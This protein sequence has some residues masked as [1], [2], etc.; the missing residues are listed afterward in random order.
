MIQPHD[1]SWL[2]ICCKNATLAPNTVFN[3]T[4]FSANAMLSCGVQRVNNNDA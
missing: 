4:L 2:W 3:T 1:N